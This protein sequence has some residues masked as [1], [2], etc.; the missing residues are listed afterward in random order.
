MN[1]PITLARRLQLFAEGTVDAV[2]LSRSDARYLA[3]L[4]DDDVETV[5]VSHSID[6]TR[7]TAQ[8]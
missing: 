6:E 5:W 7:K 4:V 2:I 8:E 3:E 1:E